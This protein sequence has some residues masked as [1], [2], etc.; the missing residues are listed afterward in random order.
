MSRATRPNFGSSSLEKQ[1]ASHCPGMLDS[2]G[3]VKRNKNTHTKQTTKQ[4]Q[5]QQKITHTQKKQPTKQIKKKK[6]ASDP[7]KTLPRLLVKPG[8][9]A[10]HSMSCYRVPL[11]WLKTSNHGCSSHAPRANQ[12]WRFQLLDCSLLRPPIDL[13]LLN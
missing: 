2:C 1:H 8:H 10:H 13:S 7:A 12:G 3:H 4:Q 6:T 9:A 5:Q 11:S